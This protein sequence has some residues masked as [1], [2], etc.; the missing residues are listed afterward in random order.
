[1]LLAHGAR[2]AGHEIMTQGHFFDTLKIDV[3]HKK[4]K[5][6]NLALTQGINLRSYKD[7][8]IGIALDDTITTQDIDKLLMILGSPKVTCEFD[9]VDID[10]CESTTIGNSPSII[11]T[12][13]FM[14]H[15]IFNK[16]RSELELVRYIKAGVLSCIHDTK[17]II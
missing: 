6:L 2:L 11:R 10:Q 9:A 15:E 3:G 7:S 5:I 17:K 4:E 8:C 16:I 14:Q 13:K 12:S 1:V